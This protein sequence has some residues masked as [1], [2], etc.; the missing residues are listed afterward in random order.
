ML[1]R[2]S[3]ALAVVLL[4]NQSDTVDWWAYGSDRGYGDGEA[5]AAEVGIDY[6]TARDYGVVARAYEMSTRV[7]ILTFKHYRLVARRD[8]RLEWLA[9]AERIDPGAA[10]GFSHPGERCRHTHVRV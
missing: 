6:K 9:M 3:L 1:T 10:M 8:D 7:D 4:L 2:W 5:L